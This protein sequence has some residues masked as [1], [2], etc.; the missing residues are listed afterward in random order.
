V[1]RQQIHAGAYPDGLPGEHQ[2]AAEFSVSRNTVREALGTL[3]HEG[4]I[5]RGP[6][7][8][9]H[10][11]RR[12]YPHGLDALMGLKE[13]FKDLGEVRNEVRAAMPVTAPPSVARRL[14]LEPG[15][16]AVFA[17]RLRYLGDLP[18]S[19]DLTYL[20][21]DL[22]TRILD[23]PLETQDLFGLIEEVSGRRLGSAALALE[24]IPADAHSAATLQ[25]PEGAA[26]L[27]LERLTTLD[28]GRPVD[29]EYI[30]MRGD[31]I[32]MRGN[33]IRAK[34]MRSKP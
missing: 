24:A 29:L 27:M 23:Y 31:R 4:L 11:A 22:G 14:G 6:K 16:Q 5:D 17:E 21:P 12:K 19:L 7:V 20:V 13:T 26:L 34:P 1:L 8:G 9:T 15:G 28:D 30:R 2:L 25:V 18:L 33:L 10:V 32:T 3:K